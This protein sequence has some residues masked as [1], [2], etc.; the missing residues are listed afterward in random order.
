MEIFEHKRRQCIQAH[1]ADI[2]IGS[3]FPIVIQSMTNT[4]TNDI[5]GSVNQ[6]IELINAGSDMVRLTAQGIREVESLKK[7]KN[8]LIARGIKN[9][10]VA[11]IHF[12]TAAAFKAATVVD[13]VRINPGNFVDPARVFKTIDYT[14]EEYA[15]ELQRL[16][17]KVL[18]FFNLCKA[19]K[20]AVRIGV[21]HGSLSDRIMSRYGNT[22]EGMVES[23]LEFLRIAYKTDF[24]DIVVSIKSSS[25]RLMIE[26]VRKLV[27]AMEAENL[28]FPLHL[29]VTEAGDGEDARI[30]SAIG[31]GTLL[32]DGI[33]D[34][35][36]VS[37]SEDPVNEI[38]V[39]RYLID[40]IKQR[41]SQSTEISF[42][43]GFN[44]LQPER[45]KSNSIGNIGDNNPIAVIN[46]DYIPEMTCEQQP[47]II[48]ISQFLEIEIEREWNKIRK[49]I[50]K[51]PDKPL[52][53]SSDKSASRITLIKSLIHKI[54]NHGYQNPIAVKLEYPADKEKWHTVV[55]AAIDFGDL[56]YD[57][58]IDGM[59]IVTPGLTTPENITLAF[60]I[61]QGIGDRITKTEYIACP[62]C[63]R[64]LFEL[65]PTLAKVREATNH[66][67]GLK[68]GVM[69]CIVNGPGEMAGADYGYVGAAKGKISLYRGTE[70]VEKNIDQSEAVFKLIDL[71][72]KDGKWKEK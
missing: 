30:K 40:Y 7:I 36:R 17:N 42:Y 24:K 52:L 11:D 20:I 28:N 33:G 45:R 60:G 32:A 27:V 70:C 62:G 55:K 39:A 15:S 49:D 51:N 43:D 44:R 61:L 65:S 54:T 68:I 48:S 18:P 41:G 58:L 9:P 35:I 22:P 59:Y 12:N 71:L 26:T 38:P 50:E 29:G 23:A 16:E 67:K 46:P 63:G 37:L 8:I 56:L 57:R 14:E 3:N 64:T 10:I 47:D 72:K 21:N 69:G 25:T 5:E 19:N 4:S 1:V 53:I 31:I 13:K 2:G 66:L 34:T 6:I